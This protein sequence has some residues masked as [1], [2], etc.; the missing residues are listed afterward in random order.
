MGH[1]DQ[2]VLSDQQDQLEPQVNKDV[3][4]LLVNQDQVASKALLEKLDLRDRR[5]LLG[6]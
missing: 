6:P 4:E 3:K 2:P 1:L 5:D